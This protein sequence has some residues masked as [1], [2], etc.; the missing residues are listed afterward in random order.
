MTTTRNFS[1]R[2]GPYKATHPKGRGCRHHSR[3][4]IGCNYCET[5]RTDRRRLES[6]S[7]SR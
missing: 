4:W 3:M 6:E 5:N 2:L 7:S 1:N